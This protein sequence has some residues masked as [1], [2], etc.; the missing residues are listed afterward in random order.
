MFNGLRSRIETFCVA[1]PCLAFAS[2][3]V[4]SRTIATPLTHAQATPT[5]TAPSSPTVARF[6]LKRGKNGA[7]D[8]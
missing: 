7:A 3:L 2:T 1:V 8:L 5:T 4:L 6:I